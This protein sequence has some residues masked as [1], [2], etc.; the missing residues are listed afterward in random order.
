MSDEALYLAAR[1]PVDDVDGVMAD[2]EREAADARA[3]DQA[4]K[5]IEAQG[6]MPGVAEM[7]DAQGSLEGIT[8]LGK[9]TLVGLYDAVRNTAQTALDIGQT[10]AEGTA[11]MTA[12]PGEDAPEIP[13]VDLAELA[14]DFV[15]EADAL[16]ARLDTGKPVDVFTQKAMQFALPFMATMKTMGA[17]SFAKGVVADA[18]TNYAVWDP[19]EGRFADLLREFDPTGLTQNAVIDYIVSDPTDSDA[20]G[21]FK[22]ALDGL[23]AT[24]VIGA[25]MAAGVGMVKGGATMLRNARDPAFWTAKMPGGPATQRGMIDVGPSMQT[26]DYLEKLKSGEIEIPAG[27]FTEEQRRQLAPLARKG[28]AI[29][30]ERNGR[31][32]VRLGKG[33]WYEDA[34]PEQKSVLDKATSVE[35]SPDLAGYEIMPASESI[36]TSAASSFYDYEVAP[37]V[38]AIPIADLGDLSGYEN[39]AKRIS[40]LAQEISANK[41]IEPIFVGVDAS[42]EIYIVEGQHRVRALQKLGVSNVPARL[43]VDMGDP[44][45]V[46]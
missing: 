20:E 4:M 14:P 3:K 46:K 2:Y 37:N 21:R 8:R 24:G 40:A 7:K 26:K 25:T 18:V 6:G 16:R 39:E 19:H 45:A 11:A 30:E 32:F 31:K 9:D 29:V 44:D 36:N 15:R 12:R 27:G 38:R 23:L 17:A 34:T 41:A 5:A 10:Q 28:L 22:N 1:Q 35:E 42:G 13:P 43:I 33:S